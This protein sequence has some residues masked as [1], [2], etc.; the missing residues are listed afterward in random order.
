MKTSQKQILHRGEDASTYSQED[1]HAS[2]SALPDSDAERRTTVTSGRKCSELY[3]KCGPLSS[4]VKTLLE[5]PR[6]YSP[7]MRLKWQAD[8]LY[9]ERITLKEYHSAKNTSSKPSVATLNVRDIPSSR[10]LFRLVPSE[11]RTEGIGCGLL[12][13]VQTQGLKQCNEKGRMEFVPLEL[14]PTPNAAEGAKY[15]TTYNPNS[16]MDRGLTAL[17]VNGMLPTLMASDA[18]TGAIIGENDTSVLTKNGTPR[19]INQNGQN[20]SIGL[21][22]MVQLSSQEMLP[23]PTSTDYQPS[24]SPNGMIRKNGAIRN[25]AL[26][27]IP[28]MMGQHC[29]QTGGKTSQ[30]NPLFV[31]EMMSFPPDWTV[32][33]FLSGD[34][35]PSKPTETP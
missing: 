19:K 16:Q 3:A 1:S 21:A 27:N 11:H 31:A 28:V 7:A 25:D 17:A 6:W 22:R 32:L 29:Q 18:T 34:K 20:G 2:R 5:S 23:T 35:N 24:V 13:T 26:R 12:P 30:L 14:L 15:S 4:L 9:S 8:A 10:L 33:P